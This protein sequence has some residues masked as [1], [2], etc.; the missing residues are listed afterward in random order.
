MNDPRSPI[1]LELKLAKAFSGRSHRI[2]ALDLLILASSPENLRDWLEKNPLW[3][4]V[5][6][7]L[8]GMA[9]GDQFLSEAKREWAAFKLEPPFAT[10]ADHG[11]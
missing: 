7:E 8:K 6:E 2:N 4:E 10:E 3:R 9:R 11:L 5:S 1:G